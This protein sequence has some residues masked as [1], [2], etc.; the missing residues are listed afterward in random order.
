MASRVAFSDQEITQIVSVL[1]QFTL[2]DQALVQCGLHTGFRASELGAMTVGHVWANGA[3]RES[4]SLERR[5]LKGGRGAH[6]RS[7]RSRT[8]PLTATAQ[9][10]LTRYLGSRFERRPVVPSEHLFRSRK[11]FGLSR[12]QINKIIHRV[13][14]AARCDHDDRIGAHSLRKTFAQ[15]IYRSSGCDINLTR[16]VM[17]HTSVVTTQKYLCVTDDAAAAA[18]LALDHRHAA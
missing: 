10:S 5:S 7:V 8:L 14:I 18:V 13:A 6:R 1:P 17:G 9:A 12:W 3:I 16:A 4:I 2:R 15:G 11:G